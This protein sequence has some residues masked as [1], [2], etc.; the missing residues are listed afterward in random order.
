MNT[1]ASTAAEVGLSSPQRRRNST[2]VSVTGSAVQ[3]FADSM[4]AWA[5]EEPVPVARRDRHLEG[6]A[7]A[8]DQQRHLDAGI[9]ERP[10]FAEHGGKLAHL[11]PADR[12]DDVAG[13]DI[14]RLRRPAR[15]K[16][17]HHDLALHLG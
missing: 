3:A 14:R 10:H 4:Q 16:P 13:A 9:A 11:A 5:L 2:I 12:E 7:V 8:I 17:D 1:S 15:R 6:A